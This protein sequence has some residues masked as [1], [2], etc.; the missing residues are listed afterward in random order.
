M[1]FPSVP[2]KGTTSPGQC[3]F[4]KQ[5]YCQ[6]SECTTQYVSITAVLKPHSLVLCSDL[7]LTPFCPFPCPQKHLVSSSM[8][9]L[10]SHCSNDFTSSWTYWFCF[11]FLCNYQ[12]QACLSW[13]W[14]QFILNSLTHDR[15]V[16][17]LCLAM[18]NKYPMLFPFEIDHVACARNNKSCKSDLY[19]T[20][21]VTSQ[22]KRRCP[23]TG[24]P[25]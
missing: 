18:Y 1:L 10:A 5:Q 7:R 3:L 17:K 2:L 8:V 20:L 21:R 19:P 12:S 4:L 9:F 25:G 6:T 23:H 24:Q 13:S 22:R 16:N 14:P 11:Y 15:S